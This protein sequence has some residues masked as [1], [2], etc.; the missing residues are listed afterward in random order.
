MP[1]EQPPSSPLSASTHPHRIRRLPD[2]VVNRIAAGE[3]VVRP[4]A[5]LKEL[6]ENSLDASSTSITVT[7]RDGGLKLLSVI[8]NGHGIS[9]SDLPLL[10]ERY[11]TS[12]ITSFNDLS[13]IATFGF[14]GEALASVSH[15]ARLSVRS[16][17]LDSPVAYSA[18]YLDGAL[19]TTPTPCAA[20]DGTAIIVED[21]FYN[22]PTRLAA[23]RSPAEEYRAIV[24]VVTRYAIRY[25]TVA[26]VCRRVAAS[27]SARIPPAD[28]RTDAGACSL[29]N[30]RAAFGGAV[31][32]ETMSFEC[33]VKDADAKVKAIVSTANF[34]M[35]KG[36][37][38][39]FI[40]GRLV[41]CNPFK[42]A[43]LATY[44]PFL[45][46]GGQPF[47][48]V[49]LSMRQEDIDVNVHPMKKEVRFLHEAT[50]IDAV[51]TQLSEKLKGTETSRTFLAQ[52]VLVSD[53][54]KLSLAADVT[55]N[56]KHIRDSQ[57]DNDI[58]IVPDGEFDDVLVDNIVH[59]PA[60]ESNAGM[61]D[62]DDVAIDPDACQ[63]DTPKLLTQTTLRAAASQKRG[64][65]AS[66]SKDGS[67]TPSHSRP[68]SSQPTYAKDMVRTSSAN[69]VGLF[70]RF[71]TRNKERSISAAEIIARRRRRAGAMPLLTSVDVLLNSRR[72]DGHK[73]LGQ[74]LKEHTFV[75]VVSAR[76]VLLQ[77]GTRLLLADVP[78]LMTELM[79]QQCLIRFA[80]HEVLELTPGAPLKRVVES[81]IAERFEHN[82]E[83]TRQ[84]S[85]ETCV[86][87]LL[88]KGAMLEEYFGMKLEGDECESVVLK[89]VPLLLPGIVPDMHWLG[90][91]VYKLV[92]QTDWSEEEPCFKGVAMAIG[93]WY[94]EHWEVMDTGGEEEKEEDEREWILNQVVFTAMRS[95]FHVPRTLFAKDVIRELTSTSRLYRIFERC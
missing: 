58:E 11:A 73:D 46:K 57:N 81:Y 9:S 94:G 64:R 86:N 72:K 63:S 29:D 70:D 62:S 1:D 88:E 20:V 43:V 71:L 56:G 68:S 32:N 17:T 15:V 5:A 60:I 51:V 26:F 27:N 18:A 92:T 79:F 69:P 40:N 31:A 66:L 83:M 47:A 6:L 89:S 24:D 25:P 87:I 45:P 36:V 54:P 37:F 8:D 80:D 55:S 42:R 41:E 61:L 28:V 53:T 48:Y 49:D 4:S 13:A 67:I 7:A 21:M 2:D 23:L 34:S 59:T 50:I 82:R 44:A 38:I 14:R 35:K 3:V 90:E 84:V 52:S 10:C 75:G 85:G 33:E 16:K 76:F 22:L 77:H 65:S 19:R 74:I 95:E 93:E 39:L 78:A 91:F 12:K 30:I